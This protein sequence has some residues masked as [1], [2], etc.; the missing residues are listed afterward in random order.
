MMETIIEILILSFSAGVILYFISLTLFQFALFSVSFAAVEDYLRRNDDVD[1]RPAGQSEFATP[2][3]VIA[4][5]YNEGPT[6]VASVHSLLRLE[7][8]RFEVI[9]VND[10]SRDETLAALIREFS[11]RKSRRLYVPALS[12]RRVRGIYVSTRAEWADLTIVDKENGGKA[13]A[14][15]AGINVSRNP[16]YCA[17]DADSVLE[18]DALLKVA[19]PFLEDDRVV[20][21]GGIVRVANECVVERGRLTQARVPRR[22]L[23]VFQIVEYLRAFLSGRMGWSRLNSLLII[24]GAFGLFRRSVVVACG[25]YSTNTVGEDMELVVRMHRYL[26]N[27]KRPY[28]MVFVPDPVCWTEAPS[29]LRVL[30]RQRNRWQRGLMDT[31]LRNGDMLLAPQYGRVGLLAMPYFFLYELLAPVIELLGYLMIPLMAILGI[32]N[33]QLLWAFFLVSVVYGV[34]LSLGAV[35][36]EEISFHRYPSPRDLFRLMA[37]AVM[38]NFGYRQLSVWWR[39]KGMVDHLRGVKTWGA[40]Q[41]TGFT[42]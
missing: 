9:V 41:R 30:G 37:F 28:R 14:L 10:G 32:L 35:L 31:L 39:L 4:P 7:Y 40:M 21:V 22:N 16:L 11:L 20:A 13:D 3:S 2:I 23:P 27:R 24:S 33:A 12:T 6:I 25:G 34:L 19:K 5:A 8:A 26:L 38:E 42:T 1:F 17:I 36:L 29:S 18:R 15:N